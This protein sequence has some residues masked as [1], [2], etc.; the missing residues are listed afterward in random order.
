[1]ELN[2]VNT[3][4]YYDYGTW[5]RSRFPFRVQKISVDAGFTCPNRDGR[6]STGGCIFCNNRTFNPSYCD[7]R[8]SISQQLEEGKRFFARKYPDMKY[9]AYFQAYTNTYDSLA[10][11]QALY[12]E[13]LSVDDIVGL[14]IGTRPDCVSDELLDYLSAADG[15]PKRAAAQFSHADNMT[16][17]VA[18]LAVLV[19]RFGDSSQTKNALKAFEDR[20]GNDALVMDK[21]FI[22]QATQP[23]EGAL[24]RVR[25]L[26]T[27]KLFSLDNP[28]RTRGLIGAFSSGNQ[29]GFNRAD[30]EGYR[31][32]AET[33]LTVDKKNP[34]LAARLLT[35]MRSWR[36][37]EAV[38]REHAREA[39]ASIAVVKDLS[40]DVSDI[41]QRTLA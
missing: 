23:G 22:V 17:R 15:S 27:H 3:P 25:Y 19:Q 35:A 40:A 36:S 34:Q 18:A 9:L 26:M 13:A 38:R 7:S 14:V 16:D 31:F 33:I 21:W 37:F 29:T 8:H 5:I 41:V 10:R 20:F 4:Y 2:K 6:I 30:G 1:M 12:E 28:N 11:L 39:L 32:F 24:A